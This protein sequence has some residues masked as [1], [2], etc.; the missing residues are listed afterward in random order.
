[1]STATLIHAADAASS[2]PSTLARHAA[3]GARCALGLLFFVC[4]LDGFLHFIPQPTDPM[5]EG[6]VA[7][8]MALFQTGY[9]VPLIAGTEL[10]GGALLLCNRA[11]AFAL[12]LLAPVV[13]N[14]FAFHYFLTPDS[15]SLAAVIVVLLAFLAWTKRAAYRPLFTRV[16]AHAA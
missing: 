7:F 10:A 14:I 3:T 5:P 8:G 13:V 15:W 1:M 9:L 2:L 4:G 6:A 11:V 16:T 12:V